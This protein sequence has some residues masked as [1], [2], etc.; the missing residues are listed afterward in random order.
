MS[1]EQFNMDPLI[2]N[3]S[4]YK[5]CS[6]IQFLHGGCQKQLTHR[7][8]NQ[9]MGAALTFLEHLDEH[10]Q[11]YLERI[12]TGDE[13]SVMFVNPEIKEQSKPCMHPQSLKNPENSNKLYL[14]ATFMV[15]V[16]WD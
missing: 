1:S 8:K 4:S 12:I 5:I 14:L 7:H 6:V 9:Q 3:T 15:K 10:G 2:A 11:D 13:T 16:F